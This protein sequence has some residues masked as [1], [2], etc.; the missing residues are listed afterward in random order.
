MQFEDLGLHDALLHSVR[1][2]GFTAP[3]P[4]QERAIPHV[5]QG[6]D[7]LGL[8]QT[9][10]GKT[11]AFALPS[12]QAMLEPSGRGRRRDPRVLVLAPTRELVS[13]V[14]ETF[15]THGKD[16]GVRTTVI[17]GGVGQRPQVDALRKGTDVVVAT[18]GRLL[19]LLGQGL[20]RLDAVGLLILDEADRMLDMGF[21]RPIRK[22]VSHLP[23][24]RQSLMF[25]ATMPDSI[26][27]LADELLSDPAEV[28]VQPKAKTAPKIEQA[29]YHVGQ[30][31]KVDLLQ[32][33]L[34]DP[35]VE[36]AIVF[37]RTKR[38]ADRLA[39]KLGRTSIEAAVIHGNKSQNARTRALEAFRRGRTRVLVAT[40][41][42]ARGIDVEQVSHVV[43]FDL[44][45]EPESYVHRIGRTGRAGAT[46]VALSFCDPSERGYLKD[47]EKLTHR[48]IPVR[49]DHPFASVE[50]AR[51]ELPPKPGGQRPGPSRGGPSRRSARSSVPGRRTAPSRSRAG[52]VR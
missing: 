47:I 7:L 14:A 18:P 29:L 2:Q 17:F 23:A 19:D 24:E 51:T 36:R 38:G 6:R 16:L 9:G 45:N 52:R 35:D 8:A 31:S 49:R 34:S 11:A 41:V 28:A 32:Q 30:E 40:D 43:N 48:S 26:R 13:Q 37:T 1:A 21:I 4:I 22:I 27:A 12:L 44:P 3:T 33:L 39:Q 50:D 25:S 10:S 20:I 15:R 5:L 42:A 46:G